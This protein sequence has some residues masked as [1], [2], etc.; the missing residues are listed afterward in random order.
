LFSPNCLNNF[1]LINGIEILITLATTGETDNQKKIFTSNFS[2]NSINSESNSNSISNSNPNSNP[3]SNSNSMN[4]NEGNFQIDLCY[5]DDE[6]FNFEGIK[7][8]SNESIQILSIECLESILKNSISSEKIFFEKLGIEKISGMLKDN[9]FSVMLRSKCLEFIFLII[10]NQKKS[11]EEIERD[12]K[13]KKIQEIINS[14]IG[15]N[16]TENILKI[17]NSNKKNESNSNND[18]LNFDQKVLIKLIET[19][20]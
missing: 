18:I 10:D 4:I 7:P 15:Q 1:E 17:F 11:S 19:L 16:N 8:A 5:Q 13:I 6:N 12:K 2:S 9:F 14:V 3:N 20:Q